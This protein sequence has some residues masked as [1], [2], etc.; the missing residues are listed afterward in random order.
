MKNKQGKY[1]RLVPVMIK[2]K[3]LL[4]DANSIHKSDRTIHHGTTAAGTPVNSAQSCGIGDSTIV[5]PADGAPPVS[6]KND[7][8]QV[9]ARQTLEASGFQIKAPQT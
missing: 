9:F 4:V 6:F 8:L 1:T 2:G 5:W 7:D 3:L